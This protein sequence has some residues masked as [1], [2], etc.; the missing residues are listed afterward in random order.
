MVKCKTCKSTNIIKQNEVF[1]CQNCGAIYSVEEIEKQLSQEKLNDAIGYV[2]NLIKRMFFLLEEKKWHEAKNISE[3]VLDLDAEN[4]SAY[5]GKLMIDLHIGNLSEMSKVKIDFSDN[6][7]YSRFIK[8]GD[9]ESVSQ[10]NKYLD[11]IKETHQEHKEIHDKNKS[12]LINLTK[13]IAPA[14]VG[15][16][17]II[18]CLIW[19]IVGAIVPA[20][21]Y[22]EAM[23][24]YNAKRYEEALEIF[25]SL[26]HWKDS[27]SK[28]TEL[29]IYLRKRNYITYKNMEIQFPGTI[30][31]SIAVR[32]DKIYLTGKNIPSINKFLSYIR[33]PENT[34]FYAVDHFAVS[35]G[36]V[37]FKVKNY[38]SSGE[39]ALFF[40]YGY[41]NYAVRE[42]Q[43][44]TVPI[45]SGNSRP[46]F[47]DYVAFLLGSNGTT[48]IGQYRDKS[49]QKSTTVTI[50]VIVNN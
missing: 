40:G 31:Y 48:I 3:R 21:R 35:N 29:T 42:K 45:L 47:Y 41:A 33:E 2:N 18:A 14:C 16:I 5:L 13:R 7:N 39:D 38:Y 32:D 44:G 28:T 49:T 43:D 37:S 36:N 9:K 30:D 50:T 11:N 20:I 23:D 6:I 27:A 46:I 25:D 1:L 26:G 22:N 4:G 19:L 17:F 8:F 12:N 10:V 24:L 15:C 34:R